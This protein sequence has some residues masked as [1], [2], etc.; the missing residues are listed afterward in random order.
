LDKSSHYPFAAHR[1]PF[2][3]CLES[4]TRVPAADLRSEH[5]ARDE[6]SAIRVFAQTAVLA[7]SRKSNTDGRSHLSKGLLGWLLLSIH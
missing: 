5:D 3:K 1:E 2:A 4:V 6:S 7:Y